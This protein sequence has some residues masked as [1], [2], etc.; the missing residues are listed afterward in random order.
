MR[1]AP[2]SIGSLIGK[3][4]HEAISTQIERWS[5]GKQ[6]QRSKALDK[7]ESIITWYWN[8][9]KYSIIE[10]INGIVLDRK[11][12]ERF[13]IAA[14]RQLSTFFRMIWPQFADHTY[15]C[16]EESDSFELGDINVYVKLD[17]ATR[18]QL[19]RFVISDWKTGVVTGSDFGRFQ[20]FVYALWA[21]TK[22]KE[23]L[24]NILAQTVSLRRG[25]ILRRFPFETILE[26]IEARIKREAYLLEDISGEEDFPAKPTIEKCRGCSFLKSC[27]D[28]V[29]VL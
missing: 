20:T 15:I 25:E 24:G 26:E 13:V 9:R 29:N 6:V 28:G 22:Y 16:H 7:A 18:D 21:Q 10:E 27:K 4:V 11:L 3:S 14:R 12:H 2:L 1:N 8:S 19:E 5:Q 23:P 17:L